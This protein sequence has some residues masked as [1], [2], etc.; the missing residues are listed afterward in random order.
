MTRHRHTT[1]GFAG[2][3]RGAA[4][5]YVFLL[6]TTSLLAQNESRNP[7]ETERN[8]AGEQSLDM[9]IEAGY[10][11]VLVRR[12]TRERLY[13]VSA[14]NGNTSAAV[15]LVR[16]EERNGEAVVLV[17]LTDATEDDGL[18]ALSRMFSKGAAPKWEI[19]ITDRIPLRL[20]VELGAGSADLDV[21][22][23]RLRQLAIESGAGNVRLRVAEPNMEPMKR[24]SI[25]TGIGSFQS[26]SLGN[27]GFETLQFEGGMGSY[28]LDLTGAVRNGATVM[29][30]VGMG[31]MVLTLPTGVGVAMRN[32]E[33][34]FTSSRLE[35]FVQT[36][37]ARYESVDSQYAQRKMLVRMQAGM[38]SVRVQW[39]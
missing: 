39:K 26:Q 37:K 16:Y 4:V 27:L 7:F 36:G 31:T 20:R 9:R 19:T 24:V 17:D 32:E 28:A 30:D 6:L 12:D 33:S 11:R 8:R 21:T 25:E 13:T 35:G 18:R 29:T 3:P 38:G 5:V 2:F 10:A 34:W 14:V 23:L 1:S 22:G 15:P